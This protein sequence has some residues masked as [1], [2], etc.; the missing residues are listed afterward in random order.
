MFSKKYT[1]STSDVDAFLEL[2]LSSLFVMMQDAATDH[3]ETLGVGKAKTLDKGLF[4][5]ITRY[6]VDI[7]RMPRYL[8]TIVVKTYPGK[9]MRF[10]FP[11]YF[12]IE[13]ESG[14][15]LIRASS[16]WCVLDKATHRI[17]MKPFDTP[18]PEEHLENELPLPPKVTSG[19]ASIVENR[20][21]RYSEV[22]L[23]GHLNNA[24][25]ITYILDMHSRDFYAKNKIKNFIINYER[26]IIDGQKVDLL[27]DQNLPSEYIK[28]TVDNNTI[29]EVNVTYESR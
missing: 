28:G 22:D 20:K 18:L 23:N 7:L 19:N 29:F 17:N 1:L 14:E 12:Q 9:D 8:E 10:I 21:V 27:S 16:T 25:Y 11:R 3:A 5:V 13:S 26:E 24:S 15:V 6:L 4:W 2:K